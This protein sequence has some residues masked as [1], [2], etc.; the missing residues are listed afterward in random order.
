M[1]FVNEWVCDE[2]VKSYDL[3]A[4][5]KKVARD[6]PIQ[7]VWT[8]DRERNAF[9]VD[10]ASGRGEFSNHIDFVLSWNGEIHKA[11]MIKNND[12]LDGIENL[13]TTWQLVG[14]DSN[15]GTVQEP[16][17]VVALLKEALIGYRLSGAAITVQHH[18]AV[19]DF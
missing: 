3:D 1:A 16:T 6:T 12:R 19:F 15:P 5:W 9:L 8:I 13:T 4:V 11:R 7:Y 18:N 17:E 2:D 10:Y 14:I